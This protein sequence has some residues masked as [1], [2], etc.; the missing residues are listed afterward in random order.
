MS[1]TIKLIVFD[2]DGTLLDSVP[3]LA[4]AVDQAVQA[5]GFPSVSEAQ[6]RD[7][8]GNGADVLIARALSRSLTVD[9]S[10]SDGLKAKTR[11]LFDDFYAQTGHRLSHLYPNVKKT[12]QA[13]SQAEFTLAVVTNKP[14]QFV[15]EIFRQHEIDVF[16]SDTLGG[17][18]FPEKKPNPVAL[19]WLLEKYQL[20]PE[21]MIMVGDSKNDIFAAQNAGCVSFGLTYGYNHGEPITNANPDY[22]ADDIA[23]LL[24]YLL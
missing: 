7:Y 19:N 2:L 22:V 3:D 14:S 12:L 6:V 9:Q 5:V 8:V 4:V 15:P 18:A 21:Q 13:L 20:T 23:E 24:G 11:H 1:D 10:L 16:F 17:D